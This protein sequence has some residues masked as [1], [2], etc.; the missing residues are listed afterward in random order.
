ATGPTTMTWAQLG[1]ELD[2]DETARAGGADLGALASRGSLPVRI[3]RDR[4]VKALLALKAR[5]DIN[6]VN[7]YLDLEARESHAAKPRQ[8]LD[9]WGSLPRLGAAIRQ[10]AP[11]VELA[12][13]PVPA[14]VTK[15][16]L[17]ISDISN[18]LGHYETLFPVTDRDRNFNLKLAA[19]KINGI[20]LK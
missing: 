4:A 3:D 9:V 7:A 5:T 14:A 1:G 8:R 16:G 15:D 17:G 18:V 2:P 12:M 13:I 11:T 19:S 20:V 10:G 6:P